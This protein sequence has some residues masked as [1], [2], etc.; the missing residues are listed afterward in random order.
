MF[1]HQRL[2]TEKFEISAGFSK[3]GDTES[4]LLDELLPRHV[5]N[6]F[7]AFISLFTVCFL[8]LYLASCKEEDAGR[9]VDDTSAPSATAQSGRQPLEGTTHLAC[10][11]TCFRRKSGIHGLDSTSYINEQC[12]KPTYRLHRLG[13]LG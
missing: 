6:S 2:T 5:I 13:H 7:E 8:L 11:R 3:R 1:I 4:L 10:F 12:D 9:W